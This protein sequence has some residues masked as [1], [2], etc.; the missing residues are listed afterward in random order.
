MGNNDSKHHSFSIKKIN[1]VLKT[2]A[3][4]RWATLSFYIKSSEFW[5]Q[6]PGIVDFLKFFFIVNSVA[7][8]LCCG[9]IMF[10][11]ELFFS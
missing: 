8:G 2:L 11:D 5:P 1:F 6:V 4:V 7:Q 9:K 10:P 3:S